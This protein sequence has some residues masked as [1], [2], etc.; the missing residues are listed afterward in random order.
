MLQIKEGVKP[1]GKSRTGEWPQQAGT[2]TGV[3]VESVFV[4]W[5]DCPVEDEMS[6]DEL[7]SIR[8]IG[9]KGAAD[10]HVESG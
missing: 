9:A 8:C 1:S 2:V 5:H 10:V 3:T 6:F 4:Q 7:A